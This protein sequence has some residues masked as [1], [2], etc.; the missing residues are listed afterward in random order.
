[1]KIILPFILLFS[2]FSCK[3]S[4]RVL[5]GIDSTPRW[6]TQKKL[7][8]ITKRRGIPRDQAFQLDTASY[9]PFIQDRAQNEW[10]KYKDGRVELTLQDSLVLKEIKH[11]LKDNGQPV[12]IRYFNQNGEPI[13]KMINCFIDPPI[14]MRWNVQ[15]SLD[16]F[17]PVPIKDLKDQK[18]VSIQT[19]LPFMKNMDGNPVVFSDLPKSQYYAVV[20][21]NSYMIRPSKRLI[22]QIKR[23][24]HKMGNDSVYTLFVNNHKSEIWHLMDAEN[25]EKVKNLAY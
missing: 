8:K 12:Q 21:W 17:P 18:D 14:P 15:G 24:N 19:L 13:F 20:F 11:E 1:M 10:A 16:I 6:P 7:E 25:K 3:L 4:Y 5:L 22:S 9:V 23:Y 2:L